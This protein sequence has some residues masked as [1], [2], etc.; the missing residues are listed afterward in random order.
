ME[1]DGF[2]MFESGA[3]VQYVL[4]RYGNG[5]YGHSRAR[6]AGPASCNGA[7]S[8][9]QP[10]RVH[11]ATSSTTR[12]QAEAERI[13]A[14]VVDARGRAL[15]CLDAVNETVTTNSYLLGDDFSAGRHHDGLHA[16]ARQARWRLGRRS[17]A[18]QRLLRASASP[19]GFSHRHGCMMGGRASRRLGDAERPPD[20]GGFAASALGA[21]HHAALG[22]ADPEHVWNVHAAVVHSLEYAQ[23]LQV[24]THALGT[25]VV[26]AARR[27]FYLLLPY[28]LAQAG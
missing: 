27:Q 13:P 1:D 14:V 3:M 26:N 19:C 18:G 5:R 24:S 16:D 28:L 6:R 8:R 17:P 2:A 10:L 7:G 23:R 22:V 15:T 4:D 25:F 11:S 12:V 20:D 9:K 21:L